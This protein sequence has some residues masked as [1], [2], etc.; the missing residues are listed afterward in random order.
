MSATLIPVIVVIAKGASIPT[1]NGAAFAS[2]SVIVT[3]SSGVAQ[4]AVLLTG[5]ETPT[6]WAF[7]T[8]VAAGAGSVTA[9]D[10]DVNGATLGTP[11]AQ[12]F[13][14]AGTPPAFFPSTG[15]T[16]TPVA[17]AVAAAASVRKA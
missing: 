11:I 1:P 12:A 6:P 10:L 3:D 14:E 7:S 5:K 8:S 2:T 16:V 17:A 15:I 9:T 13:T 4:P